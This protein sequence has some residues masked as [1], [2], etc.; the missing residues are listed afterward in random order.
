MTKIQEAT[1]QRRT[2]IKG[3]GASALSISAL[4]LLASTRGARASYQFSPAVLDHTPLKPPSRGRIR[5]AFA[6]SRHANV[7]DLAGPWE[8]FQDVSVRGGGFELYT[9][10]ETL[11]PM[12]CTGGLKIVPNYTFEN[13]PRPQLI[14]VGA[15]MGNDALMAWLKAASGEA[16]VTMSVCTGAF[17]LAKA[18]LLDGHQATTHHDFY[19]HFADDFPGVELLRG[20]RFVENGRF[21]TAGGL[22]SGIDLALRVVARYYGEAVAERTARYM[23]YTSDGWRNQTVGLGVLGVGATK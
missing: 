3:A 19:D 5:V 21:A 6:I 4:A 2:F 7:I 8:T 17:K 14:S 1:M 13:A 9:V 12:E 23:E 15:Q 18:G 11:E 16:D 10:G 20:P 22:T